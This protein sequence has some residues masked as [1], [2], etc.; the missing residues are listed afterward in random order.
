MQSFS[1]IK[2]A[3]LRG[4]QVGRWVGVG[5]EGVITFQVSVVPDYDGDGSGS[6][7]QV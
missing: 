7:S 3:F 5:R 4:M 2:E 1:D 6:R